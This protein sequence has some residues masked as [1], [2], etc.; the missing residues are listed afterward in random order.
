MRLLLAEDEKWVLQ[1]TVVNVR[2][3]LSLKRKG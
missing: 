1:L 3:Y 2:V